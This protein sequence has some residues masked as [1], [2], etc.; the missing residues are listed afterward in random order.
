MLV[1]VSDLHFTDGTAASTLNPGIFRIFSGLMHDIIE[2]S[3][4]QYLHIVF[5]GDISIYSELVSGTR[6]NYVLG[7]R[8]KNSTKLL[9]K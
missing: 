1:F 7:Q 9:M 8:M 5:L 2:R 4:P 3:T 6:L